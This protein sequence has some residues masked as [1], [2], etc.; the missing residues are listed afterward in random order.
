MSCR[1]Q[2]ASTGNLIPG[3]MWFLKT[4]SAACTSKSPVR[5][6][7]RTLDS[8]VMPLPASSRITER[9]GV[10]GE[11]R[12]WFAHHVPVC[13]QTLT[14]CCQMLLAPVNGKMQ[15]W[16]VALRSLHVVRAC[17]RSSTWARHSSCQ[18][19]SLP[20]VHTWSSGWQYSFALEVERAIFERRSLS[21]RPLAN[22]SDP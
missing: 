10:T 22:A 4:P 1:S 15:T 16:R 20:R 18:K 6:L 9:R 3:R 19:L 5:H 8:S 13:V 7:K 17:L 21:S 14:L 12:N 11:L 2:E